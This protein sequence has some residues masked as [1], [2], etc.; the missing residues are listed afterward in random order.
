MTNADC[1]Q[2]WNFSPPEETY[3][4]QSSLQQRVFEEDPTRP[5]SAQNIGYASQ[6]IGAGGNHLSDYS[7]AREI[8]MADA[9]LSVMDLLNTTG[10][11]SRERVSSPTSQ[12]R[13]S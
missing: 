2:V 1:P 5:M 8:T 7:E 6:S 3:D 10:S 13:I 9:P 4:H 11:T 12:Y